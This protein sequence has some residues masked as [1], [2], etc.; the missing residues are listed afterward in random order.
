[1]KW[2]E[3]V[4]ETIDGSKKAIAPE[5]ISASRSTDIPAFYADWFLNRLR[6]GYAKWVNPFNQRPQFIS[7]KNTRVIVF[8]SKNPR[9]M[10][11]YLDEL[12]ERGLSY[13]FHFTLND[14]EN[15][16]LEPG[17]APIAERIETFQALSEKIGRDSVIWR[18]D[19]LILTTEMNVGDLLKKIERI[20]KQIAPYTSKL[21]FSFADIREY[22]KV[23]SSMSRNGIKHEEFTKDLMISAAKEIS[24]LCKGWNIKASTCAEPLELYQFGIEHNKCIDEELILKITHRSEQLCSLFGFEVAVQG[25][26]FNS[27]YKVPKNLKDMGQRA[28][29]GC[30]FSKDIGQYN[31]CPHL[32]VY[33]YANTSE[34]VVKKNAASFLV[35]SDT[36]ITG[37]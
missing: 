6:Q 33:C 24:T 34:N 18:F 4:I 5:I 32:C 29:C 30:V 23:Q 2:N 31:T 8:W 26:L 11:Q 3:T 37:S 10:I 12:D 20:G 17:V 9:Q 1:M 13:Y 7:F 21:V 25:D 35:N 15:E 22:R 19:P 27:S 16:K 14:Y 36:I 28:E